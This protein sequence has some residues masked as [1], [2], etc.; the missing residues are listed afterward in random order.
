VLE[1][2]HFVEGGGKQRETVCTLS[3]GLRTGW[4]LGIPQTIVGFAVPVTVSGGRTTAGVLGYFSH[5]L[6]F[7][8]QP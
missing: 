8:R 1:F 3:P 4:G 7:R 5:E 2:E 6:A